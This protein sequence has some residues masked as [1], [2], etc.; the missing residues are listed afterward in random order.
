M[1]Y[2]HIQF[3][4]RAIKY[5]LLWVLDLSAYLGTLTSHKGESTQ[6]YNQAEWG[7]ANGMTTAGILQR[8]YEKKE[9]HNR[10]QRRP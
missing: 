6:R 4:L 5:K 9:I 2:Y 1:N 8:V 7:T 3:I 10:W